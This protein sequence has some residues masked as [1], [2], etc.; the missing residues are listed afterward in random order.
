M[1]M[2]RS[3]MARAAER[4]HWPVRVEPVLQN[5]LRWWLGELASF[6]PAALRHRIAGLR[7]RYVLVNDD[8]GLALWREA[9]REREAMGRLHQRTRLA[10]QH[11]LDVVLRMPAEKAL[12]I[13][14]PLPLAAERNLDQVVGFEFERLLPFRRS[15]AYYAHRV[16]ARGVHIGRDESARPDPHREP[17]QIGTVA[18]RAFQNGLDVRRYAHTG[19]RQRRQRAFGTSGIVGRGNLRRHGPTVDYLAAIC[20][21]AGG[22]GGRRVRPVSCGNRMMALRPGALSCRSSRASC[23]LDTATTRL[24][25]RPD[26]GE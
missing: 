6:V 17:R 4:L 3:A 18:E 11:P 8:A 25:P 16:L 21:S 24:R 10:S 13:A 23:S 2:D 26:P 9:G 1:K 7:S 20:G 14:A 5:A 12:R 15:E 19:F 22:G